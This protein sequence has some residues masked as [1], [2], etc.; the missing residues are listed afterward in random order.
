MPKVVTKTGKVKHL[1]YTKEGMEK[2]KMMKK[3]GACSHTHT[4]S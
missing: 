3:K 4:D 1:P 2:A